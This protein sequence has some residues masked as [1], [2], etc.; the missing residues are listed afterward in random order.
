[1]NVETSCLSPSSAL[2][3]VNPL[4]KVQ[5]AQ[6]WQTCAHFQLPCSPP[7]AQLRGEVWELGTP[8]ALQPQRDI[9]AELVV[10]VFVVVGDGLHELLGGSRAVPVCSQE[11][12]SIFP[13]QEVLGEAQ[14]FCL[15][16]TS[17]CKSSV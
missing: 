14:M 8:W 9:S 16:V 1:M 10:S 2:G 12:L 13:L 11:P 4:Q 7:P 6:P 17:W 15:S 5:L 3:D